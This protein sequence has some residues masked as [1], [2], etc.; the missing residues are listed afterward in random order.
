[1][2]RGEESDLIPTAPRRHRFSAGS[3]LRRPRAEAPRAA[4]ACVRRRGQGAGPAR[5]TS[6][7]GSRRRHADVTESQQSQAREQRRGPH[8]GTAALRLVHGQPVAEGG[9]RARPRGMQSPAGPR[10]RRPGWAGSAEGPRQPRERL[11]DGQRRRG[12][13]PDALAGVGRATAVVL[14]LT[15][16]TQAQLTAGTARIHHKIPPNIF[17]RVFSLKNTHR[18]PDLETRGI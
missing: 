12:A 5:C 10:G 15:R 11:R 18:S 1:M 7:R 8:E 16:T 4:Q 6:P 2:L 3:A 9:W 17:K 14:A 13:A